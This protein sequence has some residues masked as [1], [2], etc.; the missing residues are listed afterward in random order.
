MVRLAAASGAVLDVAADVGTAR[1]MWV[2]AP[3]VLVGKVHRER[4]A[5]GRALSE[6]LAAEPSLTSSG[7]TTTLPVSD[8]RFGSRFF[9]ELADGSLSPET[10]LLHIRR[11]SP[12]YFDAM[13]IPVLRGL[14]GTV[15]H[16]P[17]GVVE[18]VGNKSQLW[19][20]A[21]VDV[22]VAY[23]SDLAAVLSDRVASRLTQ[24]PVQMIPNIYRL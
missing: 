19:S 17:N 10:A 4:A 14:D 2:S 5:F 15:W 18:R 1:R 24:L 12:S 8:V 13:E 22:S 7:F 21:V 11:I 6:N 20:V 23:D 3:L 9:I 16:V